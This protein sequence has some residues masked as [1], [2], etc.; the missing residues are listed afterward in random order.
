MSATESPQCV[1]DRLRNAA[2]LAEYLGLCRASVYNLLDA[3][4]PSIKIGRAR[5]FRLSEVEAW[6]DARQVAA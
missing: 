4:M 2:E 5:R 1:D 3:G 6:L